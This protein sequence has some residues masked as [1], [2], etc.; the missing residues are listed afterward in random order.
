M[1]IKVLWRKRVLNVR[2]VYCVAIRERVWGFC[3]SCLFWVNFIAY[4]LLKF[5]NMYIRDTLNILR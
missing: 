1:Y 2:Q 5:D 3:I 4:T